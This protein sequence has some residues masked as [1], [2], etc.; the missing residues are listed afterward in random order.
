MLALALWDENSIATLDNMC[1]CA[2]ASIR[3]RTDIDFSRDDFTPRILP[4]NFD[5]L[6]VGTLRR[7]TCDRNHFR[8]RERSILWKSN[9]ARLLDGAIHI[10]GPN[11]CG[12]GW[13]FLGKHTDCGAERNER[14]RDNQGFHFVFFG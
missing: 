9:T 10:H 3:D 2:I 7:T 13:G 11:F 12:R 14:N 4:R 5:A 6:H 1:G 8:D